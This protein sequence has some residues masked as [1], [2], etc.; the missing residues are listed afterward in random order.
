MY[1]ATN[2]RSVSINVENGEM[3]SPFLA[4]LQRISGF[5]ETYLSG[6]VSLADA[7]FLLANGVE[8]AMD[9]GYTT[10]EFADPMTPARLSR[11]DKAIARYNRSKG[12]EA[13][14]PA[15]RAD[16]GKDPVLRGKCDLARTIWLDGVFN[17]GA[18][19]LFEAMNAVSAVVEIHS[20][21][22]FKLEGIT[23]DYQHE[24]VAMAD[25]KCPRCGRR[26]EV[27]A[28]D[29]DPRPVWGC[30]ACKQCKLSF[31][32]V[33]DGYSLDDWEEPSGDE[34]GF[35]NEDDNEDGDRSRW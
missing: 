23:F 14:F 3:A 1:I 29:P 22:T 5:V 35:D 7:S 9:D 6:K 25:Q 15:R 27:I 28:I 12:P 19:S 18:A 2:G 11:L 34:T 20:G 17:K 4:K 30:G 31:P 26:L 8:M 16:P 10:V 21:F 33:D 13:R 24:I 32:L